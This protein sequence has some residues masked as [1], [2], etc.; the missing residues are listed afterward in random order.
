[1]SAHPQTKRDLGSGAIIVPARQAV[2]IGGV[3]DPPIAHQLIRLQYRATSSSKP[4]FLAAVRTDGHGHFRVRWR[5]TVHGYYTIT[6]TY[7]QPARGLAPDSNCDLSLD[8]TKH[9][10][11]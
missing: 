7:R 11:R 2:A 6:A 10:A 5:P 3:T 8:V 4:R 1:M 9:A